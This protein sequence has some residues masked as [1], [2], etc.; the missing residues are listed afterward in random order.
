MSVTTEQI[1]KALESVF[2]P[3][4]GMSIVALGLVYGVEIRNDAVRITMTLT[5]PGCPIHDAMAGWVREAVTQ[6]PG[7]ED[8]EVAL[9]FDPP[10]SPDRIKPAQGPGPLAR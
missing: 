2:D 6:L 5:T 1:W 4:V 8:V 3:E 9:T 10:W 7:V